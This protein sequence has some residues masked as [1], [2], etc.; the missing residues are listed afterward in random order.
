MENTNPLGI[1][2]FIDL[3]QKVFSVDI[4]IGNFDDS[5]ILLETI[6]DQKSFLF[7]QKWK[8]TFL[9][10]GESRLRPFHEKYS[11]VL[12]GERNYNNVVNVPLFIPYLYS[13]N[14]L[15][16]IN[17][18]KN[19]YIPTKNV[20]AIISNPSGNSRNIFL[21]KL[22]KKIKVDYAGNYKQN[23]PL[24]NDVYNTT[25][26]SNFIKDYKFIISMENSRCDT[27]ITEKITHGF[28]A[29][30]IPVY[31]GSEN[32]DTYFNN[33]RFINVKDDTFD[34]SIEK[35]IEI[36]ENDDEYLKM[37]E[38]NVFPNKTNN[39]ERTIDV[40]A[41]DIKNLLFRSY[42][43]V[44]KIFVISSNEFEPERYTRLVDMFSSIGV[45]AH[46][47][48]FIC[49]TYKQTITPEIMDSYV[50]QNLVRKLRWLG[51]KKS[52]ISLFLN[53]KAILKHICNNYSDGNFL[54]FE[55]DV[56]KTE[57]TSKLCEFID[58]FVSKKKWDLIHIGKEGNNQYYTSPFMEHNPYRD[59]TISP[60]TPF[61]EDITTPNDSRRLI[62]KFHTR[63]T[64]SFLW[65]YRGVEQFLK[66]MNTT[67]FEVPFDYY[68]SNFFEI[69]PDFKHYWSMDTFFIQGT[70]NG[71]EKSS[72]QTDTE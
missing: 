26:F 50:K 37:I 32:I 21:E 33:E 41:N 62:R 30:N 65:R 39:L 24:L 44:D 17:E 56:Y 66:Y 47:I 16:K 64:D 71:F 46:N 15:S 31:W 59:F 8:Y 34:S 35:I 18:K 49:P 19:K 67:L 2:F 54:I 48:S 51:M 53:Y 23:I 40:I 60:N 25:E 36:C 45:D 52:E 12:Y 42:K 20:C 69:T 72:I 22:D 27:Y 63:C 38:K 10:S 70:N 61:I 13:S 28:I 7:D 58:Y 4:E 9:F 5:D 1:N 11:C 14:L 29:G 68:M 43:N 6:F 57:D 3:F 55:S